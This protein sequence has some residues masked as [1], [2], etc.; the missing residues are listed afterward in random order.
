MFSE[1]WA[2]CLKE[3]PCLNAARSVVLT[4]P[5]A[6]KGVGGRVRVGNGAE[7]SY[8]PLFRD[9]ASGRSCGTD[10]A[11]AEKYSLPWEER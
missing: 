5:F 4:E 7:F 10:D 1:N 6:H 9:C 3:K 11:P 8:L 2:D